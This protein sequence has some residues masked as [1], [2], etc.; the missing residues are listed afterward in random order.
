[1]AGDARDPLI[2]IFLYGE[3]VPMTCMVLSEVAITAT[4]REFAAI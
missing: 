3:E 4:T 2:F 1:L